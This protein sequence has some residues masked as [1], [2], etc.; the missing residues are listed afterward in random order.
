MVKELIKTIEKSK[1]FDEVAMAV[2]SQDINYE[3][4]Q[5]QIAEDDVWD[6]LDFECIGLPYLEHEKSCK[7]LFTSRDEKVCQNMGCKVNFQVSVLLKDESWYLFREMAGE[8]VDRPDISP[9]ARDVANECGGLPLAIV[10][11]GR[12]LSNVGKYAWED[13]LTQLRNFQSSSHLDVEKFVYSSI[14]L[15]LKFLGNTEHKPFLMLCGLFPEDFD[16]PIESLLHHAMGLGLFKDISVSWKSRNRVLSMVDD[17]KRKYLLLDSNVLGCVKV[18][19]IVRTV[20]LSLAF[21]NEKEKYMVQYNIKSLKEDK[22]NDI[23]AMS[24]IFDDTNELENGLECPTLKLLQYLIDGT[25]YCIGFPQIHSL[26]LRNLLN[27]KEIYYRPNHHEVKGM[28]ID[29]SYLV[30]LELVSLPRFIGFNSTMD[31][32]ERNQELSVAIDSA[33]RVNVPWR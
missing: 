17:L 3:K 25:V 18:H 4:I 21:K 13:A 22:L 10:T 5:I 9:I 30:K 8:I 28:M 7:I 20:V 29:F 12:A 11:I 26:A 33:N 27:L 19:D 16:I 6:I 2:V 31:L 24:L 23:N 15:S 14:E 1:Q 32:N